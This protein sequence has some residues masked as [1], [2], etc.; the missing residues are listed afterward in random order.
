[1]IWISPQAPNTRPAARPAARR[2]P[3]GGNDRRKTRR[4][5]ERADSNSAHCE[6]AGANE[7][8]TMIDQQEIENRIVGMRFS[9]ASRYAATD[10][11]K[12]GRVAQLAE[13]VTLNH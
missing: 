8:A 4:G 3:T 10:F 5:G 1:V 11:P 9:P 12:T 6:R 13:Q 7:N 2:Q